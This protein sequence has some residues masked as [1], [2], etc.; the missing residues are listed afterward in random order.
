MPEQD[1]REMWTR[2]RETEAWESPDTLF[3]FVNQVQNADLWC[4]M[5]KKHKKHGI[6][7][8]KWYTQYRYLSI[9]LYACYAKHYKHKTCSETYIKPENN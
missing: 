8:T 7:G 5:N 9:L 3:E 2:D 1:E 6:T 4:Q